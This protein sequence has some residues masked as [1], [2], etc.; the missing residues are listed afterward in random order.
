MQAWCY[1]RDSAADHKNQL[2]LKFCVF[3][4]LAIAMNVC[5]TDK[6]LIKMICLGPLM[7]CFLFD[8]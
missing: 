4:C 5:Q 3:Y 7:N 2:C 1:K 6:V 8:F